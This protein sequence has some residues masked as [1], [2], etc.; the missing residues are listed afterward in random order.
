MKKL[1]ALLLLLCTLLPALAQEQITD[2]ASRI[3]V[4]TDGSLLVTETIKVIAAGDQIKRG[5]Y[6]DFPTLYRNRWGLKSDVPFRV[7]TVLRDGRTE[8]W[9]QETKDNGLRI[10]L[11]SADVFLP[12]GPVTYTIQYE[13]SRQLGFFADFDELYW[14][15]T[16]NGWS[17]PILSASVCVVLPAGANVR[18][19][20]AYT[21]PKGAKG[22]DYRSSFRSGCDAFLET[23]AVLPPGSG[24]T[25]AVTWPKG[26]VA[27]PTEEENWKSLIA[28]NAGL[29]LGVA[30]LFVALVYFLT[31]W[32]FFGKDPD[33]G[34]IIPLYAP[35]DGITPQDARF[36]R[37]LGTCDQT[38]FAAALLHLAVQRTLSIKEKAR[39]SYSLSDTGAKDLENEEAAFHAALFKD[40]SPLDLVNRNHKTFQAARKELVRGVDQKNRKMFARNLHVWVIGLLVTL[41]PLGLS[42]RD[43]REIAGAAFLMVWLSIW[44]LGCAALSMSVVTEWKAR[45]F[46]SA[47]PVTL[48]ALPFL[49]GWVFGAS[50]LVITASPWVCAIYIAGIAMCAIFQHLLKRPSAEGQQLRDQIEGFRR[51]L[52]VAESERL[53]LENPPERT[54]EL[55]EKFLPYALAL[56]VSQQWAEQFAD[57]LND[58][59]YRPE[60]HSMS[61][62]RPFS[63]AAFAT[64]LA[65]SFAGAISSASTAPGSRSGSGGGGSSGGGGGGG[66]GGGW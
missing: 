3:E 38:S 21:G 54:P 35:P 15:V 31:A 8:P 49:A 11:G 43:S 39:N 28:A 23:T 5:I 42:L 47:I 51:Y 16:G 65:T 7:T 19:A 44:S 55:F 61:G 66:G 34:V 13:T 60:W 62:N 10:Y 57:V 46:L 25:I 58:T 64:G 33:R 40:G 48:F 22:T 56:G 4:R 32:A 30:G 26:F 6:R 50:M 2:F 59:D 18:S 36:L 53:N 29:A 20:E 9:R 37:G 27:A 41:V 45:R 52:A 17:F 1:T 12:A 63:A 14:N 24:F